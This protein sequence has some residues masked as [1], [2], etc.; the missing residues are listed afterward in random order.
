MEQYDSRNCPI[1]SF[2]RQRRPNTMLAPQR[3]RLSHNQLELL[4]SIATTYTPDMRDAAAVEVLLVLLEVCNILDLSPSRLN[5]IFGKRNVHT[6]LTWG[7]ILPPMRRPS[8]VRRAWVW[9]SN[10]P[11]PRLYPI[12]EEGCIQTDQSRKSREE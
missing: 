9:L 12:D 2:R 1:F 5:F 11:R 3:N 4:R 8:D 6:L 10:R 7:D